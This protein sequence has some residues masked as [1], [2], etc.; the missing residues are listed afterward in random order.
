[1]SLNPAATAGFVFFSTES[2]SFCFC[3]PERKGQ[4][5]NQ[6]K[7]MYAADHDKTTPIRIS[8]CAFYHVTSR[9]DRRKAIFED[10]DDRLRFLEILGMVV[11]QCRLS[12]AWT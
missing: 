1:M 2:R 4:V 3:Q 7:L 10:D 6:E 11:A 5:A 9:G 12:S 8:E